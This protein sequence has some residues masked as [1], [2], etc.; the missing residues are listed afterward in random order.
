M[1]IY[2]KNFF[3]KKQ[4]KVLEKDLIFNF[5]FTPEHIFLIFNT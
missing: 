2:Y 5:L 4:Q 1:Y 3:K